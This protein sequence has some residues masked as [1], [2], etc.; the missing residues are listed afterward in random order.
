MSTTQNLPAFNVFK[1]VCSDDSKNQIPISRIKITNNISPGDD[2]SDVSENFAFTQ[3][4]EAVEQLSLEHELVVKIFTK[5]HSDDKLEISAKAF[6]EEAISSNPAAAV[7]ILA[8]NTSSC[9]RQYYDSLYELYSAGILYLVEQYEKEVESYES[10]N[11]EDSLD[12]TFEIDI[13][14][15]E[16]FK[17][18]DNFAL[19]CRAL[20]SSLMYFKRNYDCLSK[21][22]SFN[23][24]KAGN[25]KSIV[26]FTQKPKR[27][28]I[29]SRQ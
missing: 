13:Y 9:F 17:K 18:L 28:P 20:G 7:K 22:F 2:V 11:S 15:I 23:Q 3:F 5:F 10:E 24:K 26:F 19:Y 12:E 8:E 27:F 21:N 14:G 1:L 29:A 25:N 4:K 6:K 16:D